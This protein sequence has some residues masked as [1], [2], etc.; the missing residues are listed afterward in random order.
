MKTTTLLLAGFLAM[1]SF[2]CEAQK[3]SK[4]KLN[5]VYKVKIKGGEKLEGR[6]ISSDKTQMV[7]VTTEGDTVELA[8][9][10]II[11]L[12]ELKESKTASTDDEYN[13]SDL[14]RY[15]LTSPAF[16]INEGELAFNNIMI[17]YSG[18]T[19]GITDKVSVEV[20]THLLG[21]LTGDLFFAVTPKVH[22]L[23]T[24][25]FHV[26]ASVSHWRDFTNEDSFTL[27]SANTTV[28]DVYKNL[29]IGAGF[30]LI[31][32]QFAEEPLIQVSGSIYVARRTSLILDSQYLPI[33]NAFDLTT[34][35]NVMGA[36][37]IRRKYHSWDLG[38]LIPGITNGSFLAATAIPYLSYNL[39]LI[40]HR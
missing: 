16:T 7:F 14:S 4:Q 35:F 3:E 29:T 6:M 8:K 31:D 18:L 15:L 5:S 30:G 32:G 37:R 33:E 20:G 22:L 10:K 12:E 26:G 34:A 17:L 40:R 24:N 21:W 25:G 9:N 1:T 27:I 36:V 19:Y 39:D 13:S 11:Q 38:I 2:I 23:E 28:G